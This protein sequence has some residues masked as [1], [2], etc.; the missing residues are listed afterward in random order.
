M[1]ALKSPRLIIVSSQSAAIESASRGRAASRGTCAEGPAISPL[2]LTN[3]RKQPEPT[4]RG[5]HGRFLLVSPEPNAA[6]L[7]V[8]AR[9]EP[10]YEQVVADV[11]AGLGVTAAS[12]R[13]RGT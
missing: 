13:D 10:A 5:A 8:C 12:R 9:G 6:I 11:K 1:V 2:K 4:T 3:G 7:R